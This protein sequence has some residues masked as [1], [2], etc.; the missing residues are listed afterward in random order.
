MTDAPLPSA[1]PESAADALARGIELARRATPGT[2]FIREAPRGNGFFIQAPRI[3]PEDGYDI[4][5]LGEDDTQYPTRRADAESIVGLITLMRTH[6]PALLAAARALETGAAPNE[7]GEP[8]GND[9]PESVRALVDTASELR[10][11][12][13]DVIRGD[14]Q[15]DS[16]TLQP[17][18][19]A[20]RAFGV[21][22]RVDEDD[23]DLAPGLRR[24]PGR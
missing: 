11:L 10:D 16:F 15:P 20:L 4:E 2:W 6:G 9:H 13:E 17:I 22:P 18:N 7:A 19:N 24:G 14:Y 3:N 1:P 23:P 12:M 21:E 8:G 5:I